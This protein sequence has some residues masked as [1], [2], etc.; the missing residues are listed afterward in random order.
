M[1][2]PSAYQTQF[3]RN[4]ESYRVLKDLVDRQ[5]R[6]VKVWGW[7]GI[8]KSTLLRNLANYCVERDYFK[9]GS[10]YVNVAQVTTVDD[11]VRA[12]LYTY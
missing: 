6:V 2:V 10:I 5:T 4:M 8:G 12:V 1:S 9:A 3:G 7:P 11:L